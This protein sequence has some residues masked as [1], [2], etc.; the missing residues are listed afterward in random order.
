MPRASSSMMCPCRRLM[1]SDKNLDQ[2]AIGLQQTSPTGA[3]SKVGLKLM[4]ID[5]V[6]LSDRHGPR[7]RALTRRSERQ[8]RG[9]SS[10]LWPSIKNIRCVHG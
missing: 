2:P 6:T 3:G 9:A 1:L 7:E 8:G 10:S 4:P 5:S